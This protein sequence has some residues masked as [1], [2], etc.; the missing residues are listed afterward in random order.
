MTKIRKN[1]GTFKSAPSPSFRLYCAA[2]E[3]GLYDINYIR[4]HVPGHQWCHPM[5]W[6]CFVLTI[7]LQ[8]IHLTILYEKQSCLNKGID[9][10]TK[11]LISADLEF[12][13]NTQDKKLRKDNLLNQRKGFHA[14]DR[15]NRTPTSNRIRDRNGCECFGPILN[16][17]SWI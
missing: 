10:F 6:L 11:A 7:F 17:R 3:K 16:K 9:L 12:T 8:N 4:G 1:Y 15:I 2:I 13:L 14:N 5:C